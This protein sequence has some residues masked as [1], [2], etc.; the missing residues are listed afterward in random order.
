M[1]PVSRKQFI[2][3]YKEM[4]PHKKRNIYMLSQFMAQS[5][6]LII[7]IH[8][9]YQQKCKEVMKGV[10]QICIESLISIDSEISSQCNPGSNEIYEEMPQKLDNLLDIF[11]EYIQFVFHPSEQNKFDSVNHNFSSKQES[12]IQDLSRNLLLIFQEQILLAN[13]LKYVQNIFLYICLF[14]KK[15]PEV[16]QKLLSILICNV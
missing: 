8:I 7:V 4:Y 13:K 11:Y 2:K 1:N 15:Y 6:K 5:L 14:Y 9:Q 12:Y 10:L 3:I 16:Y